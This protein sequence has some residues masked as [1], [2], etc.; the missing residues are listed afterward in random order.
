MMEPNNYRDSGATELRE[1]VKLFK[2]KVDILR[3]S[4]GWIRGWVECDK[5]RRE[6]TNNARREV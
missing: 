2:E 4:A 5:L 3:L 1:S 6:V